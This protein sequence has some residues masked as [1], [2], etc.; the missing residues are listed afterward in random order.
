MR[1]FMVPNGCSTVS[2]RTRMAWLGL[3]VGI[4]LLQL[5]EPQS[6]EVII[7]YL[8]SA[9]LMRRAHQGSTPAVREPV[10]AAGI[11]FLLGRPSCQ[12]VNLSPHDRRCPPGRPRL[13]DPRNHRDSPRRAGN[14]PHLDPPGG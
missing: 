14:K 11:T 6:L 9:E 2:R 13:R 3:Q 1:A 12:R 5:R 10:W 4:D 7:I 8:V